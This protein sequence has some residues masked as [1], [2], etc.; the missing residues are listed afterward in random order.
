MSGSPYNPQPGYTPPQNDSSGMKFAILFGAVIALIAANIFL[1]L[2]IDGLKQQTAKMQ[3]S[4]LNEVGRVRETESVTSAAA[5]KNME[6]LQGRV[7][8]SEAAGQPVGGPGQGRR[9][10]TRR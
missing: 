3:E 9:P 7:G 1:Y 2:Q 4:M 6:D 5:K 10:E 8:R